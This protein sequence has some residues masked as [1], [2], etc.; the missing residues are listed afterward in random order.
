LRHSVFGRAAP[1]LRRIVDR[2]LVCPLT[3]ETAQRELWRR[4]AEEDE[5]ISGAAA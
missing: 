3:N 4:R 5:R 1:N 2:L